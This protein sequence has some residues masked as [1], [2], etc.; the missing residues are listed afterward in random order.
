[1]ATL[2]NA[3]CEGRIARTKISNALENKKALA[4][5]FDYKQ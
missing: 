3:K 5:E 1:M 4:E 2:K